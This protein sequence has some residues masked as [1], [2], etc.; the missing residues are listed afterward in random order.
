MR[1]II[2]RDK[3]MYKRISA[4]FSP[5][6]TKEIKEPQIEQRQKSISDS[7]EL[8]AKGKS[9]MK[10]ESRPQESPHCFVFS[11]AS[12]SETKNL[13]MGSKKDLTY[14]LIRGFK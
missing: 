8:K 3:G 5:L 4:V 11:I 10:L 9:K 7:V 14:N 1:V 2:S 6:S 12:S 13:E